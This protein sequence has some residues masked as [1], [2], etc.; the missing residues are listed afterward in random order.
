MFVCVCKSVTDHQIREAVEEGIT[1][2]ESI[3]AHL[4]VGTQCGACACEV[5]EIM[6]EKLNQTLSRRGA[7]SS[8]GAVELFL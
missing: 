4:S 3:Q 5:K 2:F 1:S 7:N 6:E 8:A